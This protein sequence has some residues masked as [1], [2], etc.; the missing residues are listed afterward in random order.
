MHYFLKKPRNKFNPTDLKFY[1]SSPHPHN[2]QSA[3]REIFSQVH[4]PCI[5]FEDPVVFLFKSRN[6][7]VLGDFDLKVTGKPVFI[8][9]T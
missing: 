6:V 3:I 8:N 9:L 2:I 1:N 4:F 5:I 7:L